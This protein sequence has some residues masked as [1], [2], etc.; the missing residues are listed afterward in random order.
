MHPILFAFGKFTIYT[1]GFFVSLAFTVAF[2]YLLYSI[3][4]SKEKI[5][6]E[7][8]F[9]SLFT[10]MIIL[11]IVG[12]RL[13]FILTDLKYFILSPLDVFKIWQGGLVYYG[14]FISVLIFICIYARRR[15]IILLEL[16]DFFAP[17][18]AL[19]HAI[20]RIGCFFAG[21]CYGKV[22]NLPWAII[23]RDEH[24]LAVRGIPLHPTQLYESLANFLLFILL[25]FYSKKENKTCGISFAIYLIGYA[26]SRFIIEFF[27]DD[28]RGANYLGF[29][30]S[31]IISVFLFITGVFTIWKKKLRMRN[32]KEKD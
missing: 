24:S 31:Q 23:F 12:G 29:S 14:G 28:Y 3:K 2:F 15:K 26:I 1:Y 13:L 20:G 10:Y 18:L 25:H 8:N 11:G 7:D 9:Y 32:L 16:G 6:Q 30:I 17:A 19:G 21:C 4:K 22:S 27:R 5:I